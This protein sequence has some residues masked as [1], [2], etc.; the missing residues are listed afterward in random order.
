MLTPRRF[1]PRVERALAELAGLPWRDYRGDG[2]RCC[3]VCPVS[4]VATA[5]GFRQSDGEDY[6]T[7]MVWAGMDLGWTGGERD[8]VVCAA[9]DR[10]DPR[11][12]RLMKLLGM[13]P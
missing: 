11:R 13:T 1:T 12:P 9:D 3:D 5:N 4:A 6:T 7:S 8:S 2:I 10:D